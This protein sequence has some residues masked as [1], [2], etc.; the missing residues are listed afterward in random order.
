MRAETRV[1]HVARLFDGAARFVSDCEVY[2]DRG[3]VVKI[4]EKGDRCP[5]SGALRRSYA[6]AEHI[7]E[8]DGFMLPGLI[9]SHHH[10]YSALARGIPIEG[11]MPDFLA[12]LERLWWRLDRALDEEAVYLS[13]L[14]TAID[15]IRHGCTTVIDHHSSPRAVRGSLNGVARGFSD[16][17]M[18]AALCYETSDRNGPETLERAI[19]ENLAF[20][21]A[22]RDD[23]ALRGLFGLHAG[24]TLSGES[25]GLIAKEKPP[26][27]PAHVHVAEDLCDVEHARSAGFNGALERLHAHGILNDTSLI[28]HGLHLTD[29]ECRLAAEIGLYVAHNPESNLN[30]RVGYADLDRFPHER[31]LLGTD[32]MNS[33]MLGSLRSA[34]L[35]YSGFGKG[36]RDPL[37]FAMEMLFNNP[38]AYLSRLFGR[39]VGRIAEGEPADFA[40][41]PYRTPT[42]VTADNYAAHVVYALSSSPLAAWVYARGEPVLEGGRIVPLDETAALSAARARSKTVW[43]RYLDGGLRHV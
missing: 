9:N 19:E 28:A 3:R 18:T 20:E 21:E 8:P 40:V 43:E 30:N 11:A 14:V 23:P 29:A 32:G 7:H 38:A 33:D 6:D 27:V 39:S 36:G 4:L 37:R 17:N 1:F 13:S 42:A 35:L 22:H 41:F 34:F 15:S 2:V 5:E 12:R 31:V 25:L 16:L 10:A 24:F 26:E